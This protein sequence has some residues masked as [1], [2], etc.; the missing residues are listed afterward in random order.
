MEQLFDSYKFALE[1]LSYIHIGSGE[2]YLPTN[3]VIDN[4]KLCYFELIDLLDLGVMKKVCAIQESQGVNQLLPIIKL[5]NEDAKQIK[6][7]AK[8]K[9]DVTNAFVEE[10][11]KNLEKDSLNND[12]SISRNVYDSVSGGLI[13]P[14]S[15][16][17][18][19][20]RTAILETLRANDNNVLELENREY[21]QTL[22]TYEKELQDRM[23]MLKL[24]DVSFSIDKNKIIYS[25]NC[26]KHKKQVGIKTVVEAINK[27]ARSTLEM[28]IF[29]RKY[30]EHKNHDIN[31]DYYLELHVLDKI[32]GSFENLREVCNSFYVPIIEKE[33]KNYKAKGYITNNNHDNLQKK[34]DEIKKDKDSILIRVGRYVGA[35]SITLGCRG[36]EIKTKE[37]GETKASVKKSSESTTYWLACETKPDKKKYDVYL[38]FGWVKLKQLK[39]TNQDI[40][41][42]DNVDASGYKELEQKDIDKFTKNESLQKL[43]KLMVNAKFNGLEC[44]PEAKVNYLFSQLGELFAELM[45]RK[46][47]TD[48]W[49]KK[50]I[51]FTSE[52]SLAYIKQL[53]NL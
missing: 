37:E 8:Y 47:I 45:T 23:K 15:S 12:L 33:L 11:K 19:A 32:F 41:E 14:G 48:S 49:R 25:V 1:T 24:E 6:E 31:D 13:I 29:N 7:R 43:N 9:I 34:I 38:P 27:S 21:E 51:T 42:R 3:Y 4:K 35:E 50:V 10:Y 22:L 16:I 40:N 30:I 46:L 20:I 52:E 5:F 2:D 18:G 36:I 17:K 39:S 44:K 28:R 26:H 53:I